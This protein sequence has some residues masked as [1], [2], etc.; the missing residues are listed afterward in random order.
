MGDIFLECNCPY[1][2]ATLMNDTNMTSGD[3]GRLSKTGIQTVGNVKYGNV[4]YIAS[5]G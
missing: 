2:I 5:L 3:T 4:K 1:F